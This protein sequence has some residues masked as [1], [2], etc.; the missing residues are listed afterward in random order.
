MQG[1]VEENISA[2]LGCCRVPETHR[3][4]FA[5]RPRLS[6]P[7]CFK[8]L[9][10]ILRMRQRG[11]DETSPPTPHTTTP[12]THPREVRA[13][14]GMPAEE[15]AQQILTICSLQLMDGAR[16]ARGGGGG[17]RGGGRGRRVAVLA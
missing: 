6:P 9:Q 14:A 11:R 16:G 1:V 8:W 4:D 15:A 10:P 2:P 5:G 7:S 13:T 3:R 12:T 17:R